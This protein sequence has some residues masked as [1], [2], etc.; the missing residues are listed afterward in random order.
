M[1]LWNRLG[2]RNSVGVGSISS[3]KLFYGLE[4]L[5]DKIEPTGF[6]LLNSHKVHDLL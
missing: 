3:N 5:F 1:W 2:V 4:F 6:K